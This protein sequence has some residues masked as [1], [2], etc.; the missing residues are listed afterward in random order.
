MSNSQPYSRFSDENY[1]NWLKITESLHI[2]RDSMQDFIEKE[3]ETYHKAL[4]N[5]LQL[6]GQHCEQ[7]CKNNKPLCQLCEYW[8]NEIV[9]NHNEGGKNVH[10]ENCRPHLWATNKWEV[11]KAYMPRGHKQHCEF[12]QF[13]ISAILNF[14]SVCKHFKPFLSKGENVKKVIN[15]RNVVMHSP[16][17][18]MNSEDMNRHLETIFQFADMLK[19]KVS[20]LSDLREKIK[21]FNN[22][23]DKNFNQT[24]VDGQHKDLKTVGDFQEVL[25]REQQALKDR[26]DYLIT[27]FKGNFDKNENPQDMTTLMEFLHQNKDLLENLGPEVDKLKG[28]QTKLNQ[29][30]KQ[31]N[32]LTNRVGQLEKVKETTKT[33][34]QS[35][36]QI[37]NYSKFIKDNTSWLVKT[38]KNIDQILDDLSDL[39]CESIANVRA[40]PTK[41]AMMRELL[42]YMNC[43]SIAKDFFNALLKHEKRPM[44]ELL[45][46]L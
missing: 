21:Q 10:W 38:V 19:S 31:I 30:E 9:T 40:K 1:K 45:K 2:L 26:I 34:G 20:A 16:D 3:T 14:L 17:L 18:K 11:A 12:A 44:E 27:H 41:Q 23:L 35:S 32:N 46:G 22:I 42:L 43:E 37:T 39:H 33:A 7:T 15:V 13:D 36:S 25:N 28:M 24:E 4:Q 5:K 8:K 29:H 6:S